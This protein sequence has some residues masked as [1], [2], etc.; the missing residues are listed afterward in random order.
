MVV[1]VFVLASM[2]G[3]YAL[4]QP[5]KKDGP[6]TQAMN[7]AAA[8]LTAGDA[9]GARGQAVLALAACSGEERVKAGELQAA[10]ER[11]LAAQAN[12]ERGF[13]R[14]SSQ[15]AVRSLQSARA[16]LDQL[17]T[18]CGVS[19]QGKDLRTQ[20]ETGQAAANA[21]EAEMRRHLAAGDLKAARTSLDQVGANNR[22]HPDLAVLR[23]ELAEA[24]KAAATAPSV[25][26]ATPSATAPVARHD[27]PPEPAPSVRQQP[28]SVAPAAPATTNPQAEMAQSFLRDA[29]AA[30]NQ[31][32][33]DA[34][35][36]FV[37]S[38]RRMDPS[39]PQVAVMARRIKEREV[40]YL[41]DE[42]SI[43]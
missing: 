36:T 27:P 2:A 6:C 20:I 43:K 22:E 17:D 42:T 25:I 28:A 23:Q 1:V 14:T 37:E 29:E 10:A 7:Q 11:A 3:V 13:R 9:T 24:A 32:K 12:C 35:K 19:A 5:G 8:L 15:I 33:F 30:L 18:A 16:T 39:N 21:A 41:K 38:A 26:G 40:Q 34:A 4:V 31:L